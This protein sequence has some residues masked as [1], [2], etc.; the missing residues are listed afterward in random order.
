[1][2]ANA[3]PLLLLL[4]RVVDEIDDLTRIVWADGELDRDLLRER[5]DTAFELASAALELQAP[6]TVRL[7]K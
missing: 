5:C 1:M 4:E 3:T 6:M 2:S 7:R